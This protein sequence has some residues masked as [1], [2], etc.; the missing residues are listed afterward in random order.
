VQAPRRPPRSNDSHRAPISQPSALAQSSSRPGPA[1][2]LGA[3]S[4]RASRGARH[5]PPPPPYHPQPPGWPT[6][7]CTA[8]G[9]GSALIR[10]LLMLSGGSKCIYRI[11]LKSAPRGR[12]ARFFGSRG[13][14]F[15]KTAGKGR[16]QRTLAC[17]NPSNPEKRPISQTLRL[18]GEL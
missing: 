18:I 1:A 5:R 13:V 7:K 10:V 14:I 12:D 3:A 6:P 4:L 9:G 11:F 17:L 16:I 15:S 8:S 2:P